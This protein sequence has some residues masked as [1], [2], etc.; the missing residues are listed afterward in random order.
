MLSLLAPATGLAPPMRRRLPLTVVVALAAAGLAVGSSGAGRES[1]QR[2][3][4]FGDSQL[5]AVGQTPHARAMLAKGVELDLRAAVCR[6]L[7]Q[8]SCPFEGKRPSTVLEEIRGP[9][10]LGSAAVLLV[11]YNDFESEWRQDVTTILRALVARNVTRVLWLTLTERR[12][13]WVR[14]NADLL[15]VARSWP[16][17]EVLDWKD[18]TDPTWFR[19]DDIHLTGEGAI[20]LASYLHAVLFARGIAAPTESAPPQ[21]ARLRVS[22]RGKGSV[23]VA[24]I[25]CRSACSR[26]VSLGS[27]TRLTARAPAGSV[28]ERWGGACTGKR[29]TCTVRMARDATVV[30]RFRARPR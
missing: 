11:G 18:A 6:R 13:D 19:G 28:F 30:A 25:R 8:D 4:V 15:A 17:L 2:V 5:T 14:M 12:A 26:V 9:E 29:S 21:T 24:G 27:V 3:S 23:T 16:Q 1:L 7:V 20:G 10:A 22:I